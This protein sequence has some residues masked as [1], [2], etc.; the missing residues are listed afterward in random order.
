M[1][2]PFLIKDEKTG[3]SGLI[4][5]KFLTTCDFYS[6]DKFGNTNEFL[7]SNIKDSIKNNDYHHLFSDF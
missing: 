5:G 4:A 1:I 2:H 3:I 6:I 7:P